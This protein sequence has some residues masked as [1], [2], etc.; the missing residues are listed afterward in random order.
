MIDYDDPLSNRRVKTSGSF[1]CGLSSWEEGDYVD[2]GE[3][4]LK[5][6]AKLAGLGVQ[7]GVDGPVAEVPPGRHTRLN[8]NN[9]TRDENGER[10]RSRARGRHGLRALEPFGLGMLRTLCAVSFSLGACSFAVFFLPTPPRPSHARSLRSS[11][12]RRRRVFVCRSSRTAT[13]DLA[14]G[15]HRGGEGIYVCH[16]DSSCLAP[17]VCSCTDGYGG[18]DCN[19]PLCRHLRPFDAFGTS[20]LGDVV[21]CAHGAPCVAKDDCECITTASIL[22]K[23]RCRE[24]EVVVSLVYSFLVPFKLSLFRSNTLK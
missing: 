7:Y 12:R 11:F 16:H 15:V 2:D 20:N 14:W 18:F 24:V 10:V 8:Y 17:E 22:W 21:S 4:N 1:L 3:L 19:L 23:V 13:G 5:P 6:T 9:V